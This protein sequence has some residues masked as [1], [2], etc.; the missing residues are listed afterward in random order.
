MPAAVQLDPPCRIITIQR[1]KIGPWWRYRLCDPFWRLY[2][3]GQDGAEVVHPGGI[4]RLTPGRLHLLPA[5][6]EFSGRCRGEF[7]H[8][9]LHCDLGDWG[10]GLFAAPLALPPDAAACASLRALAGP[11]AWTAAGRLRARALA[12]GALAQA[13]E[14]LPRERQDGL[15]GGLAG[16]DPVAR[17]HRFVE[18]HL[19]EDLSLRR[20]AAACALSPRQLGALFHARTGRTPMAWLR[21]RRV[22][23][24]A[25]LL[26]SDALPIEAVAERCGFVNRHHF[27]RIFARLIGCGPATYRRQHRP[28]DDRRSGSA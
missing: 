23:R 15:L 2:L 21:E 12:L 22:A 4:H 5:W 28:P 13:V 18:E 20:L 6:G 24:A 8:C 26:L 19:A 16:D 17:A 14:T 7:E 9:Y 1:T 10:R 27:T 11:A 3:N 25:E